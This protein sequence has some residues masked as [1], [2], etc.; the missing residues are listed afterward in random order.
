MS[1]KNKELMEQQVYQAIALYNQAHKQ[2][3]VKLR[4]HKRI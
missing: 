3:D 2:R 4:T 1:F